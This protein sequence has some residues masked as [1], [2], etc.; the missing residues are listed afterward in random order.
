MWLQHIWPVVHQA[1]HQRLH[2]AELGVNS[3]SQKHDK[4]EESPQRRW[5]NGQDNLRIDKEGETRARLDHISHL[6]TLGV[7]HVAEDGE[8]D[9]GGEEGGEGVDAAD[10]DGVLVAVVVEL[11]VAAQGQQGSNTN[12]VGKEDL[13]SSI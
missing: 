6:H 10:H 13:S 7:G 11:V 3:Q 9:H 12:S 2:S 1:C 4:E 5:G 8:D